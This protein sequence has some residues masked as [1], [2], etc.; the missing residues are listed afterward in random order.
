[1][2]LSRNRLC[3]RDFLSIGCKK[4]LFQLVGQLV[5]FL[6]GTIHRMNNRSWRGLLDLLGND[7]QWTQSHSIQD[8]QQ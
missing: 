3:L 2:T 5:Y 4:E 6:A 7:E 1:M 8:N